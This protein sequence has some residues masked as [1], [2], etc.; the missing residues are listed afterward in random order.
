[1]FY[2]NKIVGAIVNPIAMTLILLVIG[3]VLG[4]RGRKRLALGFVGGG[5]LWL[6]LWSTPMLYRWIGLGLEREWPVVMAE[7]APK[8]D[9]IVILGGGMGVNTN[10]YKYAE[11]WS[12][13][14][15]VWHAARLW[16]AGKAPIVITSGTG[17][18]VATVPLLRDFV[19]AEAAIVV[20]DK[21]RNTEE[22]AKFV[23]EILLGS[24]GVKSG[25]LE[26]SNSPTH[27]PR[28]SSTNTSPTHPI[29]HSPTSRPKVLLVTSAWHMR[30]SVL[31]F[32]KYAPNLEIIPSA[33]DYEAL[34]RT[35]RGFRL[36]DLMPSADCLMANSYCFKE[37]IGYWGYRLFR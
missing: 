8:A 4:T 12:A 10:A 26:E 30:R 33:T 17:E 31:M 20:E 1:M 25:G 2:L 35:G 36:E 19:V 15:R 34:V 24:G 6:W 23:E 14:D 21:A 16:K 9:A 18:R 11:M 5:V 7:D 13:A 37:Y 27:P 28:N 3:M 29:P 22:N 32:K